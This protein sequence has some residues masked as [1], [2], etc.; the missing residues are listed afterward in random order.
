[1]SLTDQLRNFTPTGRKIV[2]MEY[3]HNNGEIYSKYSTAPLFMSEGLRVNDA[4]LFKEYRDRDKAAEDG[5]ED[6]SPIMVV[7]SK[8]EE[9]ELKSRG[10]FFPECPPENLPGG[11]YG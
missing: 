1:M 2:E 9:E 11:Y 10:V 6:I 8:E 5:H 4:L 3:R 7:Y